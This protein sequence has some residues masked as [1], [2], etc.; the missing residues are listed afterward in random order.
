M[1]GEVGDLRRRQ[2]AGPG[3]LGRGEPQV[4]AGG[5]VDGIRHVGVG[6]RRGR[7]G[8]A[9]AGVAG[10]EPA[11]DGLEVVLDHPQRPELVALGAQH[12]AQPLDVVGA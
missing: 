9:V 12:V 11:V 2:P 5:E 4:A 1:R 6:N 10:V 8:A 3:Q 7:L